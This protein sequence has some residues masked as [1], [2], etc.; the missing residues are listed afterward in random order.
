MAIS[1]STLVPRA[2]DLLA[3]EAE[4]VAGILLTHLNSRAATSG[5]HFSD[6]FNRHNFFNDLHHGPEYPDKRD[7]VTRVLMEAWAWLE[8]EGFIISDGSA[9]GWFF[10]SRRARRLSSLEAFQHYR[11]AS[12]LPRG[13]LHPIIAAKVYPAFLRGEHDTAVFQAFREVEILVRALGKFSAETVGTDLMRQ[14][15]RPTDSSKSNVNPGPLT[16]SSL[17]IAEQKGMAD[18]FSGAIALF[19]NPR[20]IVLCQQMLLKQ[21]RS[22]CSRVT[23]SDLR[24]ARRGFQ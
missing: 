8:S 15:F 14:A 10:L 12:L 6:K 13:Q 1:L 19:K 5:F 4:E 11:K 24:I 23:C 16:D 21:R 18:L 20:V 3:L 7:E 22:S 9:A 2:E 17:P